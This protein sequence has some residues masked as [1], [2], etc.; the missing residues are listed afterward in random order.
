MCLIATGYLSGR[1]VGGTARV[2]LGHTA[3]DVRDRHTSGPQFG[4]PV[5]L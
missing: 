1:P 5:R 2:R 4:H 3:C